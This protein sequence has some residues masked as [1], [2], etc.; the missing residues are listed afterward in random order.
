MASGLNRIAGLPSPEQFIKHHLAGDEPLSV[1]I[2]PNRARCHHRQK[3]R[4]ARPGSLTEH[5]QLS[6]KFCG[7]A[8]VYHEVA[9]G[10]FHF[11]EVDTL[12]I[13]VDYQIN[14]RAFLAFRP[15]SEVPRGLLRQDAGNSRDC[16]I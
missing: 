9:F 10:E 13:P 15:W 3:E 5:L 4:L 1:L 2:L 6:G 11:T 8:F 16:L 12:I 14:L 7:V